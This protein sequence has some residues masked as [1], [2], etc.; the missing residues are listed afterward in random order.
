MQY[1]LPIGVHES[2]PLLKKYWQ[3]K[4]TGEESFA[5]SREGH[6]SKNKKAAKILLFI[7]YG[8]PD[9]YVCV[10]CSPLGSSYWRN[11]AQEIKSG[12][13]NSAQCPLLST[14]AELQTAKQS[15]F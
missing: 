11:Y 13:Q 4:S 8:S 10:Q 5:L 15:F 12:S 2:H 1:V 9:V 3:V 7:Y 6:V 14:N